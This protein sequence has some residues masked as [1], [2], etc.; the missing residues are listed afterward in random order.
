MTGQLPVSH[1]NLVL[2]QATLAES[3][4]YECRATVFIGSR[5][6]RAEKRVNVSVGE[7][8]EYCDWLVSVT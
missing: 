7:W 2:K 1:R 3:G 8:L 5:L 4:V 6:H